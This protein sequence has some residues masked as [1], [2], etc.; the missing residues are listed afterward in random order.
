MHMSTCASVLTCTPTPPL[1]P[2][3]HAC[4]LWVAC[5]HGPYA[6]HH[7]AA[8]CIHTHTDSGAPRPHP[9]AHYTQ[10]CSHTLPSRPRGQRFPAAPG[11]VTGTGVNTSA[12]RAHPTSPW[13]HSHQPTLQAAGGPGG[14]RQPHSGYG[15]SAG[16]AVQHGLAAAVSTGVKHRWASPYGR[17]LALRT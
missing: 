4:A 8:P 9:P 14:F 17:V 16:D 6:S 1:A 15:G 12:P 3:P 2:Q 5:S 7:R 10:H 13:P 11:Q